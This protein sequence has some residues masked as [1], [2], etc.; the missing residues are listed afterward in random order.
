MRT[1]KKV[2]H[3]S[4]GKFSA[5][6]DASY[7]MSVRRLADQYRLQDLVKE[8]DDEFLGL[9]GFPKIPRGSTYIQPLGNWDP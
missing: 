2:L 3:C 4:P 1:T 5:N 6:G 8:A 9:R 7:A